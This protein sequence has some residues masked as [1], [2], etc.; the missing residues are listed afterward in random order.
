MV[1]P[2]VYVKPSAEPRRRPLRKSVSIPAG[3][4]TVLAGGRA[5]PRAKTTGIENQCELTPAGVKQLRDLRGVSQV[6]PLRGKNEGAPFRWYRPAS[7]TQPPPPAWPKPDRGPFAWEFATFAEVSC[8][9]KDRVIATTATVFVKLHNTRAARTIHCPD[10][11][12]SMTASVARSC[13]HRNY[14]WQKSGSGRR[15]TLHN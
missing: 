12:E 11:R 6:K 9:A 15:L 5:R 1:K 7:G 3:M 13:G 4:E 14:G 10:W 2:P 8:R